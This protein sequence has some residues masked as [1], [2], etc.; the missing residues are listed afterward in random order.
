MHIVVTPS[1]PF[2]RLSIRLYVVINVDVSWRLNTCKVITRIV[3]N[4]GISALEVNFNVMRSI[5]S[6]F[7]LLYF[8]PSEPNV[9]DLALGIHPNFRLKLGRNF[10]AHWKAKKDILARFDNCRY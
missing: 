1:C 3:I 5:N 6:R 4:L 8:R 9:G 10:V 7:T 2:V